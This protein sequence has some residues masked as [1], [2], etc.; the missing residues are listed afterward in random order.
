MSDKDL[1]DA[2]YKKGVGICQIRDRRDGSCPNCACDIYAIAGDIDKGL[3][4][5]IY[6]GCALHLD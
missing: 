3:P 2:A 1:F 4:D 6:T 5:R